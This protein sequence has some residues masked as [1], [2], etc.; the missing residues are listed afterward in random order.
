MARPLNLAAYGT[1][2]RAELAA[3]YGFGISQNHP[4]VDGNKR[5]AF[6]ALG[7]FL[8]LNRYRLDTTQLEATETILRL[9]AGDLDEA[10]LAAWVRE[11]MAR[12]DDGSGDS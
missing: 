4:F 7:M 10:S 2:D 5:A 3:C 9:A 11:R 1:P 6:L 12:T 8:R